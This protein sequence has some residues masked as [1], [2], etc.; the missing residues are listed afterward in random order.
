[1]GLKLEDYDTDTVH[2]PVA[3]MTEVLALVDAL[4]GAHAAARARRSDGRS[5]PGRSRRPAR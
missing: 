5:L 3:T 2:G 1:M 4:I